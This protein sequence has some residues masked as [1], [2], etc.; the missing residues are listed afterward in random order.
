MKVK[1]YASHRGGATRRVF[2]LGRVRSGFPGRVNIL[3]FN[4]P[5]TRPAS[6][7]GG[8]NPGTRQEITLG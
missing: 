6:E 1:V 5:Q 4:P 2:G 3:R 8:L 7:M